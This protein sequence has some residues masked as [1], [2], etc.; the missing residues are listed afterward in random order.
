MHRPHKVM[1]VFALVAL[2]A[3]PAALVACGGSDED[4]AAALAAATMTSG[5]RTSEIAN[6]KFETPMKVAIG[7]EVTWVNTDGIDHNVIA[8]D[9]SFR[10]DSLDEGDTFVHTFTTAGTFEYTCAFHPGMDGVIQV[11]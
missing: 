7:S 5:P 6:N 3:L 8:A 4:D 1:P 2:L 11:Q 10:S 9:D